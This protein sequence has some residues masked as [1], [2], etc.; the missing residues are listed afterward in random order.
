MTRA[1]T[2]SRLLFLLFFEMKEL[3]RLSFTPRMQRRLTRRVQ[4]MLEESLK[5]FPELTGKTITIGHSQANLGSASLLARSGSDPKL[6]IRLK[7]RELTYQTI[8]HELT[9]LIQALSQKAR[10]GIHQAEI[11]RIPGGEKPCDIWTLARSRLFCDDAPTY[12]RL[13]RRIREEWP[14]YAQ[15]VRD[16]CIAAIEKRAT[17]RYYI[18][19]LE[20]ELRALAHRPVTEHESPQQLSLPFTTK[21]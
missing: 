15:L 1:H 7:V 12:L 17:Y 5:C 19:W 14:R 8:G 9:H 21:N 18:R 10:L 2:G 16:L 11:A 20:S 13:P 3:V 6:I 4:S